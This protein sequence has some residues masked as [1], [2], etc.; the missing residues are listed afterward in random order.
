MD[1]TGYF[2][3]ANIYCHNLIKHQP[4]S[5]STRV[6]GPHSLVC[7]RSAPMNTIRN[8][9]FTQQGRRSVSICSDAAG[10]GL[11]SNLLTKQKQGWH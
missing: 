6:G 7:A 5:A 2:L 4:N 8:F 10:L 3:N 9:I 11:E 1:L